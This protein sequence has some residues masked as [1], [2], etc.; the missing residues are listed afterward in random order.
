VSIVAL[1]TD[2]DDAVEQ[3]GVPP[4]PRATRVLA[5]ALLPGLVFLLTFIWRSGANPYGPRRYTLF[6][7]A[8][9]SIT[10]ARTLAETGEWVWF[11]GA[12]RVQG[13]TNPLWSLVMALMHVVGADG[14]SAAL[15]MSLLGVG[16]ILGSAVLVFFLVR[17]ALHDVPGA[18]LI[19]AVAAGAVP[20]VYP[21][22]F[23]TLRGMEVG[24]LAFLTLL[25]II[26]VPTS[27]FS[28]SRAALAGTVGAL[29]VFTRLD[30]IV[31]V[32][33]L[34]LMAVWWPFD[35]AARSDRRQRRVAASLAASGLIAVVFVLLFQRWY[36][37]D[38][39][40]NTYTLKIEGTPLTTR[41]V[42]GAVSLGKSLP[43]L[44]L[45]GVAVAVAVR[46]GTITARRRALQLGIVTAAGAAYAVWAG[47]DAW[48]SFLYSSRYISVVFPAALAAVAIG[49]GTLPRV[50]AVPRWVAIALL[51]V[52]L[53]AIAAG[54]VSNPYRFHV[55]FA[56]GMV[57]VATVTLVAATILWRRAES[58][59]G[60]RPPLWRTLGI[61]V[62]FVMMTSAYPALLWLRSGGLH[63]DDDQLWTEY[64]KSLATATTPEAVIAVTRAGVLP[65]AADRPMVDLLGKSDRVIA[66]VAPRGDF[67][68][69]HNKYD[70]A[71]SVGE[72][73]PD[74]VF[75]RSSTNSPLGR[76]LGGWGYV[77]R[78]LAIGRGD[79]V[80]AYFRSNSPNVRWERLTDCA[81]AD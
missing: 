68:P 24:L 21:S 67:Y 32:L 53:S 72:L 5:V 34:A 33:A 45:T 46:F 12:G 11:P 31:I 18:A 54:L 51:A 49:A 50:N 60:A 9:I 42:R 4:S 19:A 55:R 47:G 13:I 63:V 71:Y 15:A 78:C 1:K 39:L 79:V 8:A 16:L 25:L 57:I 81:N 44:L 2:R 59:D 29:G 38:W 56:I 28:S 40:P 14:S 22:T 48:E 73:R 66:Q 69:G 35:P 17:S 36:W 6:D 20:F 43:V 65:Y 62:V 7:D 37:G 10:Y 41:L 23:W 26:L 75:R 27:G 52:P 61:V 74:V 70:Y 80:A 3:A 30:F 64:G 58:A 77:R 76:Q